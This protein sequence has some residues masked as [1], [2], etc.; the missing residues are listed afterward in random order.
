[1]VLI[2]NILA[3]ILW[4][5]SVLTALANCIYFTPC[6]RCHDSAHIPQ[7]L[8]AKVNS[9]PIPLVLPRHACHLLTSHLAE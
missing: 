8:S 6:T 4:D 2:P 9:G 1:M 3:F 7:R 5:M